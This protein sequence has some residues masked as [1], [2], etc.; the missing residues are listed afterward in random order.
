MLLYDA[1]R[2][3]SL[4]DFG[5]L[6]PV[7]P[8]R[9]LRV[10]E[11]LRNDPA[12]GPRLGGLL[13]ERVTECLGREDL[14]RA[15]DPDFVERLLSEAPEAELMRAF[16]LVDEEGR[17]RRYDPA[18]AKLPL[19][20]LR[21]QELR[22]AAG[23]LQC[24]RMAL[25]NGFCFFFG[26]GSHHA[27]AGYGNGFC[28]V[29]D[30]VIAVRRLKAE[31]AIASAWIID[32]DA[33]KGDGTAALCAGDASIV[34]LSAHMAR[35]WPLNTPPL[36]DDGSPNPSFVPSDIDIPVEEGDDARY[37]ERLAAGLERL[38]SFPRPD[39]CV[40]VSGADPYEKDELPSTA[41]LRLSMAQ[42]EERDALVWDFLAERGIPRAYL[43]AGGY[44]K[45]SWEVYAR[46]LRKR[47]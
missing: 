13:I 23:T 22:K 15:H 24:C 29:N 9:A 35:G 8:D 21:D 44:G 37:N 12:I 33:H 30:I 26:G 10:M 11:D 31:G 2:L 27:Q 32:V 47:L 36:L 40:V 18:R 42:M 6:I 20:R 7:A 28:L 4:A 39:L 16:E 3:A 19:S 43:M 41:S 5:I 34:T 1:E 25:A 14:L 45:D 17:F 38:D 46:F